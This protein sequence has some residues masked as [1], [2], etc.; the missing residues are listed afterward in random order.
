MS[1]DEGEVVGVYLLACTEQPDV[2]PRNGRIRLPDLI[3]VHD[4]TVWARMGRAGRGPRR[5]ASILAVP[6]SGDPSTASDEHI[7]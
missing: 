1:T 4:P 6:A 7:Q 5:H 3:H 2:A